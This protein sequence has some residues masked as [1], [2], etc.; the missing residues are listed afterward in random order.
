MQLTL[1]FLAGH[2]DWL[3]LRH[4]CHHASLAALQRK[5]ERKSYDHFINVHKVLFV[6]S[7]FPIKV[8]DHK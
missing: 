1:K 5:S 2:P 6:D 8:S 4:T 3:V 7:L